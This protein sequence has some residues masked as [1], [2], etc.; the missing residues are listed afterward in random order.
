MSFLA[1]YYQWSR[2]T[3]TLP[4]AQHHQVTQGPLKEILIKFLFQDYAC[5]T[6]LIKA[7]C[8]ITAEVC[9][10]HQFDL[11]SIP[12]LFSIKEK[13]K[14]VSSHESAEGEDAW[15]V[16]TNLRWEQLARTPFLPEF[17]F[18]S[19]SRYV[20]YLVSRKYSCPAL[21][22]AIVTSST[23]FMFHISIPCTAWITG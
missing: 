12:K 21:F 10:F 14:R 15:L 16:P 18:L 9:V 11:H 19:C 20:S 8:E 1:Q 6:F 22:G 2:H 7:V 13:S 17:T 4:I 3:H 23:I 5:A